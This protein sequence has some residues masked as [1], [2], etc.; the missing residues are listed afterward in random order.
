MEPSPV[1]PVARH[2]R[3]KFERPETPLQSSAC[4][5]R[6]NELRVLSLVREVRPEVFPYLVG[7]A[8]L[9]AQRPCL[10]EL[11]DDVLV[12]FVLNNTAEISE[13]TLPW[14]RLYVV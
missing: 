2:L 5:K 1:H 3:K 11:V 8:A 10:H 6:L 4:H 12:T 13:T 9:P 14:I 7:S